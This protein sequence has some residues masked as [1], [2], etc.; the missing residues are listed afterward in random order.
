MSKPT[1]YFNNYISLAIM[2]LMVVA[3]VAGQ[4]GASD[5]AA[6]KAISVAPIAVL[7]DRL[8]I[9]LRGHIGDQAL[10]VSIAIATDLSYFRGEDE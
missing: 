2:L 5:N 1:I 7:E 10:E 4:A 6:E 8:N 9:D 3:L